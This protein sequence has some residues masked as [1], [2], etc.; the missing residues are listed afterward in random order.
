MTLFIAQQYFRNKRKLEYAKGGLQRP[1]KY[2]YLEGNSAKRDPN[3]SRRKAALVHLE[4]KVAAKKAKRARNNVTEDEAEIE[5]EQPVRQK[6]RQSGGNDG[7]DI[8]NQEEEP[9]K[10]HGSDGEEVGP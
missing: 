2:D 10:D 8:D 5:V 9:R 1:E 3:G 4:E 7:M 6:M